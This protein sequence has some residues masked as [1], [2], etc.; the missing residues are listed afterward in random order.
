MSNYCPH[1][2]YKGCCTPCRTDYLR[3]QKNNRALM[4]FVED[5]ERAKDFEG[6]MRQLRR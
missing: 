1:G 4:A 6:A 3:D 5:L 2:C